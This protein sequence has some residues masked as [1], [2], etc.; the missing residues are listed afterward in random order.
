MTWGKHLA[1]AGF[2]ATAI[3]FGPARMGFGLFLPEFRQ[4]FDLSTSLA[5]LI[6]SAGFV[7][8]LLALPLTAWLVRRNGPKLP[9]LAGTLSASIGFMAVATAMDPLHLLLGILFASAS[10]GLCWAPF[11]D[12]AERFVSDTSRASVLA[13]IA[14]GTGLGVMLAA[15]LSLGVTYN[16]FTWREAWGGFSLVA[17]LTAVAAMI[18]MP[19][20]PRGEDAPSLPRFPLLLSRQ[21]APLYLATL[22]FGATNAIYFSFSADRVVTAGGLP[23]LRDGAA[24]SVLFL[25]YGACGMI[26]IFT[27]RVEAKTGMGRLL[28]I[29]FA[30]ASVSLVLIALAPRSWVS[31]LVSS[32]LQGAALMAASAIFSIWSLRL[33]PGNGTLGFVAA[34]VGLAVGS[35]L[36]PAIAGFL[37]SHIGPQGMFLTASLPALLLAL[38]PQA[39][40]TSKG[41][42]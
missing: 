41:L 32:G 13:V 40:V 42:Q 17:L 35:V 18:E 36:G 39:L 30:V 12:A 38:W 25:S 20:T 34:L 28:R 21:A 5:G 22:C 37:A 8:F 11:N 33:F 9:V 29:V 16:A 14:S 19:G 26:G 24:A 7:A 1:I 10:A 15:L 23:G 27:G 4:S 31:V 3:A 2:G 6:A